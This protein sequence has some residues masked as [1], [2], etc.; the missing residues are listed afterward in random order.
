VKE[1]TTHAETTESK[2]TDRYLVDETP[3]HRPSRQQER[4]HSPDDYRTGYDAFGDT[5]V[6]IGSAGGDA[7]KLIRH[8]EGRHRSDGDHSTREAARDKVRITESFCSHLDLPPHQQR[9]AVRAMANLNLDRFGRQK[10]LEKVALATIKVAVERDRFHRVPDDALSSLADD[11]IPPRMLEESQY[12]NLLH[13]HDVSKSDL[14]STS[15]LV[16]RELK[17]LNHFQPGMRNQSA[18]DD[19]DGTH[20]ADDWYPS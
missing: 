8:N 11:D 20:E 2:A 13:Q 18:V 4:N 7:T 15:Q 19:G 17:K 16:K 1:Q 14:Y 5:R 10:R 6:G 3:E 9:E 12:R